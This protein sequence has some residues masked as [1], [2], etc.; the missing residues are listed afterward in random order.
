M[1]KCFF[2]SLIILL[3][4]SVSPSETFAGGFLVLNQHAEAASLGLA[5]TARVQNPSAILYNPAAINQLEGTQYSTNATILTY[6]S[7]FRSDQT[8]EKTHQN[9]HVFILPSFYATKKLNDK[10]SVGFGSFSH[11]GLTS[12]WPDDWEGRYI[13]TF[14]QLRTFFINPNVSYQLTPGLSIA[15]GINGVY[16]DVLQRKHINL[17]PFPDGR[18]RF[19]GDDIGWGY[20]IALLY[21]ITDKLK[22]GLSYRNEVPFHYEGDVDFNVPK[23]LKGLV[24]EGGASININ[25]P[26]FL[27]TGLCY[28]FFERWTVEF[29]VIWTGWST[30]DELHLKYEKRIPKIMKKSTAPIIRDYRN[31]YDFCLGVSFKATDSLTLRAGYL[32]DPSP[33]PEENVDPILPDSDKNIY[34]MGI[35]Y[36]KEKITVDVANYLVF[37]NGMHVRRNRDGLNGKY[38]TFVNMI[39]VSITY[40]P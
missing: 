5:Y 6:Q 38:D 37:Y 15:V 35:G 18:A 16:S 28:T 22:F 17:S 30:Y 27:S 11:F 12:D 32:F 3:A 29:D 36:K 39:G 21:R 25:L 24:P 31:A 23:F 13:A 19:E 10:W 4:L 9:D 2:I 33:V 26:S 40:C 34:T 14:A 7:E 8:G 1:Q 20:N